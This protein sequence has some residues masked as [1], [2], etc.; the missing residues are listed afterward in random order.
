MGLTSTLFENF[1]GEDVGFRFR[2][3][4]MWSAGHK[5]FLANPS[6]YPR[7]MSLGISI[8]KDRT[9]NCFPGFRDW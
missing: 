1:Y 6:S 8:K 2:A 3:A 4:V 9:M 7:N 5:T